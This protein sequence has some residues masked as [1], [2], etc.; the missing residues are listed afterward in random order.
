MSI[1]LS[2]LCVHLFIK[3]CSQFSSLH[4]PSHCWMLKGHWIS[5]EMLHYFWSLMTTNRTIPKHR[6]GST[7]S[8]SLRKSTNIWDLKKKN[9]A[10]IF[11]H[12]SI[13]TLSRIV[14]VNS[15]YKLFWGLFVIS[16]LK[17]WHLV[18]ILVKQIYPKDHVF[19]C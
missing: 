10:R 18:S 11:I 17:S 19:Y 8:D 9:N 15:K 6:I 1:F 3:I 14:C 7:K 12:I 13:F 16:F 4:F 5:H 2:I